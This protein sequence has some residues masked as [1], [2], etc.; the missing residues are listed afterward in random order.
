M[1]Y[2]VVT[3]DLCAAANR[4]GDA[5]DG[6][7]FRLPQDPLPS[8]SS[9]SKVS[10]PESLRWQVM[11]V[12]YNYALVMRMHNGDWSSEPEVYHHDTHTRMHCTV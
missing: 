3:S 2:V 12:I 5:L 6:T 11:D 10:P 4:K 7:G 1:F 9:L 8:L